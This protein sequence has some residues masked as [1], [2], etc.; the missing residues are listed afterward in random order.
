MQHIYVYASSLS[1]FLIATIIL[2]VYNLKN[3]RPQFVNYLSTCYFLTILSL[4]TEIIWVFID[5]RAQFWLLNH[6]LTILEHLCFSFTGYCWLRYTLKNC[7]YSFP[8]THPV[9]TRILC[10]TPVI[11]IAVMMLFSFYTG[12]IYTVDQ[13]FH[14]QRG[15]LFFLRQ[16]G[17]VYLICAS[18]LALY[19]Y[20]KTDV[21][22][23]RRHYF[24][25]ASFAVAPTILGTIQ[26]LMPPGCTPTTQFSVFLSLFIIYV[27]EQNSKITRDSLTQLRNRFEF[28][29]LVKERMAR[30][31]PT[32]Y[33]QVFVLGGDLDR[34]KQINDRFGHLTGDEALKITAQTLETLVQDYSGI[35]ARISGDEFAIML[36]GADIRTPQAFYREAQEALAEASSKKQYH[37]SMSMGIAQYDGSMT[38]LQLLEQADKNMYQEKKRLGTSRR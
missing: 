16:I 1:L 17:G 34:F 2:F 3:W 6:L 26:V 5:G 8:Q 27:E 32:D 7:H 20:G 21:P 10:L 12:W 35:A 18:F 25:I 11:I 22:L 13:H 24:V 36:E 19:R 30:Y 23:L 28:E 9:W 29:R 38:L 4:F 37:L 14:Y 15:P 33:M 31:H